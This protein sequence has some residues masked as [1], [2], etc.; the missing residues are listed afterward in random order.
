MQYLLTQKEMDE[1]KGALKD[2]EPDHATAFAADFEQMLQKSQTQ[3]IQS[4]TFGADKVFNLQVKI[5]DI[6]IQLRYLI[7]RHVKN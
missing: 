3:I 4:H 7:E 5:S 2:K 1:L 6:P